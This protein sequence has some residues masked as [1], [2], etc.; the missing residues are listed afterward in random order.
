MWRL[1][2]AVAWVV[3]LVAFCPPASVLAMPL[4]G[5]STSIMAGRS[6]H[7][8]TG[9]KPYVSAGT[10]TYVIGTQ[11]GNFPDLGEHLP[12]EMGGAWLHPIKLIDGFAAAISEPATGRESA[13]SAATDFITYPY[14]SRFAYGPV[15]DSLEVERFQFSPD[16]REGF[17][18]RYELRNAAGRPRALTFRLAVKTDLRPVWFSDQ[19]GITDSPDSAHW[20]PG[21]RVFLARD[22]GH[23]WF[24]V[25]G[26]AGSVDAQ[27]VPHPPP[28]RTRGSGVTAASRYT[29]S[30]AARGTSTLTFVFAGSASSRSAAL[31]TWRALAQEHA[32][33]LAAQKSHY[34][35]LLRRARVTIPDMHLQETYD[36]VKVNSRW[37]VREVPGIGRGITGGLMEYPWWFGTDAGYTLQAMVATGN[38]GVARETLRLLLEHSRKVNGNGRIIHEVTTNGGVVNPGNTQ[39]T[40]QF[41]M[42]VGTVVDWTG[43]L[44][45]A[46]EMYPAMKQGLQWLLTDMD[47]NGNRFPEGYGI[48]E[49]SGLNAE[50]IDVAVYTQQAL[51][52]T[53]RI[54]RVLGEPDTAARY[55]QQAEDLEARINQRF[56]AE[57]AGSYGDFY[58]TRAQAMSAAQ[59]AIRQIR[60]KPDTTL[61]PHERDIVVFYERLRQRFAAMPD[62]SRAWLTNKNWVIA[63]PLEVGIAPPARAVGLLDKIRRENVGPYGPYL[64]AVE[65]RAM[66]TI[67]TGV[68]AVSEAQ[69]GRIDESL[70][71]VGRIVETLDRTLPGSIN[72]MMPD[73]GCFAISW[74]SYG[75]MVPLI[76][77]VFG[78]RPDA[79]HRTV[80]LDP[81]V[82]TGWAA[83]AMCIEDLP[84]GS[85]TISFSRRPT[86]EGIEY[87]IDARE[88]GWTF[89]LRGKPAPGTR[90]YVN[91]KAATISPMGLRLTGKV[92]RVLEVRDE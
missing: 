76:E 89:V 32:S 79:V 77:Y 51:G 15:L 22:G 61:T 67:A 37:L 80:V 64:S 84:V 14:G 71:Y 72:E 60:L 58:G 31:E 87:R 3:G 48:M 21:R 47:R 29:L 53:A 38:F 86:D 52:T 44:A 62:S 92:N 34:E 49:V 7:G 24:C 8:Q 35:A 83:G 56:W 40:A 50:L 19:L 66:M 1:Q 5:D 16:G 41:I 46:R 73:Y 27:A 81:Q 68:Q 12:G 82:P 26:A 25:W 10:R 91:G 45:F 90:Y 39:E 57:D 11:D 63:T 74:T 20:Y 36:W 88:S 55:E 69:Y 4:Q 28:I 54:A 43:D 78:I 75:I 17:V 59:G 6:N 23:P 18:V 33:L 65:R 85:N 42:A 9:D 2:A 70:W 13:L 30:L